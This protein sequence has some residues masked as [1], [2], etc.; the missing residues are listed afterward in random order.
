MPTQPRHRRFAVLLAAF[1]LAAGCTAA[2]LGAPFWQQASALKPLENA[3]LWVNTAP[4]APAALQGKVVLLDFWTYSCI[5]CLRTLPYVKAWAR[6]YAPHGLVVIGVHTPEFGFERMPENVARAAGQLAIDFPVALDS[7]RVVWTSSGVQGWPTMDFIDAKGMRRHRQVGEGRYEESER[8]IQQLLEEAGKA[9]VPRDLVTPQGTGTQAAPGSMS[10]T[11][12]ETYLGA[13]R[14]QGFT[15]AGGTLRAGATQAFTAAPR[16]GPG[17]WTL[18]GRW[19]VEPEHIEATQA[20]G[21][22]AYR[23]RARD[24]HL[25]L[26]PSQDGRPVRFRV[27]IDGQ[28]PGNDRGTDVAGDGTGSVDSHRLYQL[29]RQADPRRERLFEIQFLDPGVRAYAFTFG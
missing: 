26:G 7:E 5:N 4:I 6:K 10:A 11:S 25:V 22:I 20:G 14:A 23:F 1:A 24:V 2:A 27:T 19:Q 17:G 8:M 15:A 3:K 13:A 28:A 16:L 29:V 9:N 12:A 21:R 18:A